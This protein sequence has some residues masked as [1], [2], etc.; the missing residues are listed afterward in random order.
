MNPQNYAS[1]EAGRTLVEAGIVLETNLYWRIIV[2]H[3]DLAFYEDTDNDEIKWE[4]IPAPSM[5]EL[6]RE[7][8]DN[9]RV[10]GDRWDLSISKTGDGRTVAGYWGQ[11]RPLIE[12]NNIN[13]ADALIDLL[14]FVRKERA[15]PCSP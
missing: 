10:R 12:F 3:N 15:N 5:I 6:W 7:L 13:P 1:L 11:G 2:T 4:S 8:P 14:I 9:I